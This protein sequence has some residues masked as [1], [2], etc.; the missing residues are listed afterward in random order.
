MMESF[1]RTMQLASAR[2]YR[3]WGVRTSYDDDKIDE[4]APLTGRR[5]RSRRPE[6]V[7]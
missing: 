1:W 4:I 2:T 5:T 7:S 3:S 6:K